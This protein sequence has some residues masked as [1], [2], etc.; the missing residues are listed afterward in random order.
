MVRPMPGLDLGDN[1]SPEREREMETKASKGSLRLQ[2]PS[3]VHRGPNILCCGPLDFEAVHTEGKILSST[4]WERVTVLTLFNP[5][6]LNF[7]S[8][9]SLFS[10]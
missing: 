10:L 5:F 9:E 3:A 8:P 1:Y 6:A 7:S 2:W 4:I